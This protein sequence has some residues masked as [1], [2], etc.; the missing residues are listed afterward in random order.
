MLAGAHH[1]RALAFPRQ[2][3]QID[4]NCATFP[5]F[6]APGQALPAAAGHDDVQWLRDDEA[7]AILDALPHRPLLAGKDGLRLSRAVAQDTLPVVFDGA[8]IGLPRGGTPSA[9]ILKPAMHAVQDSV[10]NAGFCR[11][12]A[13]AMQRKPA[14]ATVHRVLDRAFLLVER[15]DRRMDARGHRQRLHP[16]DFCQALGVVPAMQYQNEGRPDLAPCFARVRRATRPGAP[17]HPHTGGCRTN[18]STER[19]RDRPD[20]RRS[21]VARVCLAGWLRLTGWCIARSACRSVCLWE[22][23]RRPRP[24]ASDGTHR[25][26]LAGAALSG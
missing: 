11:A 21:Y 4:A 19:D 24:L 15:D 1:G 2:V 14:K 3:A 17:I 12:L 5:T 18:S 16:E 20:D 9:H 25:R 6:L 10:I 22:R 7:V 23:P 8:R 13:E 26:G